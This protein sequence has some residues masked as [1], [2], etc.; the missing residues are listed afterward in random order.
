M[1]L[2]RA[3]PWA[4]LIVLL[5]ASPLLYRAAYR[6]AARR[7]LSGPKLRALINARPQD[8]RID[9]DEAV[10]AEPGHV[11]I[12]NLRLRGSDPNV[13]WYATLETADLD[14]SVLWLLR[15]HFVCTRL[16]GS[17]LTLALR[18][19]LPPSQAETTDLGRLP[20]IPGLPDPPLKSPKEAFFVER[21][22]FTIELRHVAADR[23]DDIWVNQFHYKGPGR[24]EGGLYLKPLYLARIE[25]AAITLDGGGLGLGEEKPGL[26]VSG[27][28]TALTKLFEPLRVP[29]EKF[30]TV[31]TADAK[32]DVRAA[33]LS[34]LEPLTALPAGLHFESG[35]A[36]AAIRLGA[37]EGVLDGDVAATIDDGRLRLDDVPN[38]LGLS[39]SVKASAKPHDLKGLSLS[40][41]LGDL[42][43]D[44]Q[45]DLRADKLQVLG[46]LVHLR[47][48]TRIEGGAST[49]AIRVSAKAGVADGKFSL[50]VKNAAVR[51]KQYRLR[52]DASVDVPV[53]QWKLSGDTFDVSGARAALTD[54][55]STGDDPTR[56]WWGTVDVPSGRL[57]KNISAKILLQC[58]DARPLLALFGVKLPAWTNG[59]V[60]LDDFSATANL[61]VAPEVLRV[62]DLDAKGG[63]FH[64]QGQ[65]VEDHKAANGAFLIQSGIL[66]L[67][68]EVVPPKP[69]KVRLLLAKQWY[70]KQVPPPSGGGK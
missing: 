4:I 60:Q 17:G 38:A 47:T 24:L 26:T 28:I 13:Q 62:G 52:G 43:G 45:L 40:A 30:P 29:I 37:H 36:V 18:S 63:T 41:L 54:V 3:A 8:F 14:Y 25:A 31:L 64:V 39:G 20:K 49:A 21:N 66:L 69:A 48:G 46:K 6:I 10:S 15:R 2:R 1:R 57:G 35:G 65:Y 32:L 7:L 44:V 59:L 70:E 9:W 16:T 12:R 33:S 58:R 53:R 67:G 42:T 27:R 68:V 22:P 51:T 34:A 50:R 11:S 23:F 5:A 56:R 19:K 55:Y 61:A